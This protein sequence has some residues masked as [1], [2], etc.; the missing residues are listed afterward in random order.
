[1]ARDDVYF[2]DDFE[3]MADI[4]RRLRG[5]EH[6]RSPDG[7]IL[8]G[9]E[10]LS[11]GKTIGRTSVVN[12][13]AGTAGTVTVTADILEVNGDMKD[14]MQLSVMLAQPRF[15]PPLSGAFQDNQQ[16][17]DAPNPGYSSG[18]NS[19]EL[20]NVQ[21]IIEWGTGGGVLNKAKL[22]MM[23][24]CGVN[25]SAS[26]VRIRAQISNAG[27]IGESMTY[28]LGAQI[29]PGRPKDLAAQFTDT[30]FVDVAI[31]THSA[32]RA[33]PPFARRVCLFGTTSP[34][35]LPPNLFSGYI[36]F[37]RNPSGPVLGSEHVGAILFAG[38]PANSVP[39]P[40]P[41]GAY[42][43]TIVPSIAAPSHIFATF[44]LAI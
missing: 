19:P 35:G 30:P 44:D 27:A 39:I 38:N 17:L 15:A 24:G 16:V 42:Y 23:N 37:W 4:G 12:Y 9:W 41:N 5:Q 7:V 36:V 29:S 33:I 1:M 18:P 22:D 8:H 14:S 6:K 43:Y 31:N 11:Q 3:E 40:I 20:S 34:V 26:F 25:I 28:L 2:D 10:S 13:D 32:V 21:A